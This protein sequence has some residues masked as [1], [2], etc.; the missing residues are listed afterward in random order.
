MARGGVG[1]WH[2]RRHL[3]HSRQARALPGLA[4]CCLQQ[5]FNGS[6]YKAAGLCDISQ[7]LPPCLLLPACCRDGLLAALLDA[8]QAAAGRPIPVLCQPTAPGDIIVAQRAQAVAAP[9]VL[10]GGW[11]CCGLRALQHVPLRWHP[12]AHQPPAHQPPATCHAIPCRARAREA[13][14]ASAE[15]RRQ[16]LH[17]CGRRRHAAGGTGAGRPAP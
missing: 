12:T 17:G 16:R 6:C 4:A 15:R 10:T 11:V 9:A 2:T 3:R 7:P 13:V 1:R 14:P 8:A 5:A